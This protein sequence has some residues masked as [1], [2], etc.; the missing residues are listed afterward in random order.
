MTKPTALWLHGID[1]RMGKALQDIVA[2]DPSFTLKGGS[3]KAGSF[4]SEKGALSPS[5]MTMEKLWKGDTT[6][7]DFSTA[8]GSKSLL[9]KLEKDAGGVH[10]V[11]VASTG[12]DEQVRKR[13][14]TLAAQKSIRILEAPN[15]SVGILVLSQIAGKV[16]AALA[17]L[18]YDLE[19]VET[20]HRHKKDA[21]SGTALLLAERVAGPLGYALAQTRQGE[22]Q[23]KEVGLASVRGGGVVGEHEVRIL[24]DYEEVRLSHRAF[25]RELFAKGALILGRWLGQQK[26]GYY[27]L[28]DVRLEDLAG[29]S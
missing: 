4:T 16:A 5:A 12:L 13:F 19:V 24:G 15:T 14:R 23:T 20:H 18:G 29:F 28:E 2:G 26:A 3:S 1:G 27:T 9:D 25:S 10:A 7:L 21:P 8:E 6:I 17:P 11:L 22:R